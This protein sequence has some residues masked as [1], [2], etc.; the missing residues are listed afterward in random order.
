MLGT[1]SL[2]WLSPYRRFPDAVG[3]Y[4]S[5]VVNTEH[6]KRDI[7]FLKSGFDFRDSHLCYAFEA[8]IMGGGWLVFDN[9]QSLHAVSGGEGWRELQAK[10]KSDGAKRR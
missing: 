10:R 3:G 8:F 7:T 2:G 6:G 5:E 9:A 4:T 1:C